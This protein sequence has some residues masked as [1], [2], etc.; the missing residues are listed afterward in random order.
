MPTFLIVDHNADGRTLLART[1]KRR[2]PDATIIESDRW[3]NAALEVKHHD[4]EAIILHRT[5]EFDGL[6]LV[7]LFRHL[8]PTVPIVTVSGHD[9]ERQAL[10]AG[11]NAFL[12][13][14]SWLRIGTVVAEALGTGESKPPFTRPAK[15]PRGEKVA[16]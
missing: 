14:D 2:F 16:H 6:T 3:E 1:L 13:Y 15:D 10:A 4:P 5:L 7:A 12:N 11:A 9:M 8:K